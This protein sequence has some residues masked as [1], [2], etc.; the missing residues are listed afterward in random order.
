MLLRSSLNSVRQF[1]KHHQNNILFIENQ[2]KK[3]NGNKITI[4]KFIKSLSKK[5][6]T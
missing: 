3:F 5:I 6:K 1:R 4:L 2:I